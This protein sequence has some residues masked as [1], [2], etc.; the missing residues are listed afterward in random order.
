LTNG[1]SVSAFL[2]KYRSRS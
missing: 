1:I 2:R